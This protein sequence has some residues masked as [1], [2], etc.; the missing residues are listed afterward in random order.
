[1]IS[2]G[3]KFTAAYTITT[4]SAAH[5]GFTFFNISNIQSVIGA[6]GDALH[7]TGTV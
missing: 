3:R 4:E 6:T 2:D 1:M 5:P 7:A